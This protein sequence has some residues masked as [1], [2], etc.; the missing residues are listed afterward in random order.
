MRNMW[1]LMGVAM[2]GGCGFVDKYEEGV[3]DYQPIYCYQTLGGVQSPGVIDAILDLF[4]RELA[5]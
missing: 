2:L 5:A 4:F 3:A 1:V